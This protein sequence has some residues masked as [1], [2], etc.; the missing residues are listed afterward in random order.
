MMD[1]IFS[2]VNYRLISHLECVYPSLG[3]GDGIESFKTT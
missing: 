1:N 2:L 3:I